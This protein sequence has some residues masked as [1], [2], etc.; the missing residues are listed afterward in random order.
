MINIFFSQKQ[1]YF[2]IQISGYEFRSQDPYQ[3]IIT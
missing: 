2:I 3:A 1:E